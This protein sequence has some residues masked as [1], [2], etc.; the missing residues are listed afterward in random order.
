MEYNKCQVESP[1]DDHCHCYLAWMQHLLLCPPG[2]FKWWEADT[3][4]RST[5]SWSEMTPAS[6]LQHQHHDPLK[7]IRP[8]AADFFFLSPLLLSSSLLRCMTL[9]LLLLL[10]T[11]LSSRLSSLLAMPCS[12]PKSSG[13]QLLFQCGDPSVAWLVLSW[14]SGTHGR[15]GTCASS[16]SSSSLSSSCCAGS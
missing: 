9:L 13:D 15:A 8:T 12:S 2:A 4:Q 3:H 1:T 11:V 10:L 14:T 7:G 5:I 16:S 6:L